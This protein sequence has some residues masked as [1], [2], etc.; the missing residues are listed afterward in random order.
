MLSYTIIYDCLMSV[1]SHLNIIMKLNELDIGKRLQDTGTRQMQ[2]VLARYGWHPLGYGAEATV[3]LHPDRKYVLKIFPQNSLYTEF[4]DVVKQD[5][6]NPHF[7]KFSRMARPVPGTKYM[8]IRMEQLQR[9]Q[10]Y[11]MVTKFPQLLCLLEK[12]YDNFHVTPPH[13]VVNN[14]SW[15]PGSS[16]VMDCKELTITPAEHKAFNLLHDKIKKIGWR[17]T[18]LHSSNFMARGNTWVITDPFI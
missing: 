1:K 5:P 10:E 14:V 12:L 3:A 8:Y 16:G 11:D 17:R 9:I 7:P 18:D 6:T 15:D 4:L 13:Y 2:D